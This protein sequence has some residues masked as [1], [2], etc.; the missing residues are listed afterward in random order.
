MWRPL[1]TADSGREQPSCS[2]ARTMREVVSRF[3]GRKLAAVPVEGFTCSLGRPPFR[4]R[5]D[6]AR[7]AQLSVG[8]MLRVSATFA[9]CA[10]AGF[11]KLRDESCLKQW[12]LC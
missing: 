12:T 6:S 9:R 10:P 1:I 11:S 8:R 7:G 5:R 4:S 2:A 3:Y